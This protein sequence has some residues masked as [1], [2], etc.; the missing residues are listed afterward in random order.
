MHTWIYI[1]I[2][3]LIYRHNMHTQTYTNSYTYLYICLNKMDI[4]CLC[5]L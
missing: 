5:I 2:Y 1:N 3:V 4:S